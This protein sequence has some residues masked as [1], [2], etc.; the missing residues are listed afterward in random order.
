VTPEP[1][2]AHE[3]FATLNRHGVRY[4]IGGELLPE[5][6]LDRDALAGGRNFPVE[7]KHG[8]FDVMQDE[9]GIPSYEALAERAFAV[10]VAGHEVRV[11]S[12]EDLIAMK[13][14]AG[15]DIDRDDLRHL[16]VEDAG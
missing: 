10:S 3:L 13:R 1:L 11:C 9:L 4:V 16:G 15:R 6:G 14:A 12:R 2:A 8:R 5:I 7:T